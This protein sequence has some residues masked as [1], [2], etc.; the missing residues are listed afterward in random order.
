MKWNYYQT[1]HSTMDNPKEKY[2]IFGVFGDS[3]D[4]GTGESFKDGYYLFTVPFDFKQSTGALNDIQDEFCV[5]ET[6][7][8][9][10][11]RQIIGY[12]KPKGLHCH[13]LNKKYNDSF[14]KIEEITN[15][16]RVISHQRKVNRYGIAGKFTEGCAY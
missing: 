1:N 15:I 12:D 9:V 11:F 14:V 6:T 16:Y 7:N 4:N 13:A 2:K 5:I 8:G 3:M 10:L